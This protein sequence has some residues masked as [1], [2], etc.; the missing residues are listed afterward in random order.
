VEKRIANTTV[1]LERARKNE[2][3][4]EV[5]IVVR[6]DQAAGA[7]ESHRGWV[8]QNQ[9]YLVGPDGKPIPYGTMETTRQTD[10]EIGIAYLFNL[11]APPDRLAFVYKS[12]GAILSTSFDFTLNGIALP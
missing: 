8:L 9:A 5:R 12:P 6:F 2:A 10:N 1:V 3:A 11:D 7:L 4:W